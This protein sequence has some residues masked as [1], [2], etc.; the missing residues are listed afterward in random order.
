MPVY[1]AKP[2]LPSI[3]KRWRIVNGTIRRHGYVRHASIEA[4][5]SV[6][7]S[8]GYLD[9]SSL[10]ACRSVSSRAAEPGFGVATSYH[11]Q[12]TRIDEMFSHL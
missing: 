3:G 12:A 4:R 7:Q 2:P 11:F 1:A 9:D 8:F 5:H 6:Q 10:E